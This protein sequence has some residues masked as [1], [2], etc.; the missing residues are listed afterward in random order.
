MLVHDHVGYFIGMCPYRELRFP[1]PVRA[2][3]SKVEKYCDTLINKVQDMIYCRW[4]DLIV[5]FSLLFGN[6]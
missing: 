5:L 4:V 6:L 3:R 1:D 2:P